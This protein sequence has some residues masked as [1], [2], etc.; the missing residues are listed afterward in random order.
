MAKTATCLY[1]TEAQAANIVHRLEDAG[2]SD[3]SICMFTPT[4]NNRYW[5]GTDRLYAGASG[6]TG[7][8]IVSYLTGNGVPDSDARAY[9]EGVRR[10]NA[11]VAVRCDNDE[12]DRVIDILDDDGVLDIDERQAAWRSEGWSGYGADTLE[13]RDPP[14][15]WPRGRPTRWPAHVAPT[16]WR[17][18]GRPIAWRAPVAPIPWP[19]LAE[20]RP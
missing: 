20:A 13:R 18:P 10:G 16:R 2:I 1:D 11:L 4:E 8:R 19:A 5:E 9:A 6:D 12:A 7:D 17:Q 3:A 15:R 14:A